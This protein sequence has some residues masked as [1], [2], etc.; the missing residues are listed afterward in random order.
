[1][2]F[3]DYYKKMTHLNIFDNDIAIDFSSDAKNLV[4]VRHFFGALAQDLDF[5][6]EEA[7]QIELC[8]DEVCANSIEGIR[9]L[10]GD[11]PHSRVRIEIK[12]DIDA[13]H[14]VV[15]DNGGDFSQALHKAAPLHEY[16][17]RSHKRGYGLQIIKTFMDEIEYHYDSRSGNRLHMIKR[18]SYGKT[19]F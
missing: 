6:N 2:Q 19:K 7:L 14:I 10:E 5:S 15:F 18:K 3:K 8:V 12:I 4:I 16:T 17:D 1:M 9:K 11:A 13:L